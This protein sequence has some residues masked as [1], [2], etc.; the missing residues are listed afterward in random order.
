MESRSEQD[1]LIELVNVAQ[2]RGLN[3]SKDDIIE[4]LE[5]GSLTHNQYVLFLSLYAYLGSQFEG[6]IKENGDNIDLDTATGEGLDNLGK[7]LG[8]ERIVAKPAILDLLV[9]LPIASQENITIPIGTR[10]LFE[11]IYV[12]NR[13]FIIE[14]EYTINA[15][16]TSVTIQAQSIDHV[17]QEKVPENVVTGLEGFNDFI[18]SNPS[19]STHGSNIEEDGAFRKRIRNAFKIHKT[20]TR[21]C[22][23]DYLSNLQYLD[24]YRLIPCYNGVGTLKII[25]DTEESMLPMISE[26]VHDNCMNETDIPPLCELPSNTVMNSLTLTIHRADT[27]S[28]LSNTELSQILTQ[29]TRVFVEGGLKRDNSAHSGLGIAENFSP[30]ELITFLMEQFMEIDNIRVSQQTIFPVETNKKLK[31]NEITVVFE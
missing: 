9:E 13:E 11:E 4:E 31:I 29:Q 16:V 15:G 25:C 27:I 30:S 2:E 20:G 26:G 23:E 24:D 10:V 22:I 3:I 5:T 1:I 18:V 7:L 14:Q 28:S 8:I 21:P 12:N 19:P 17:Y 6:L